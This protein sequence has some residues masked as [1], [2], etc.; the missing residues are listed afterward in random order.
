MRSMMRT[1]L[2]AIKFL[3]F[4]ALWLVMVWM[5]AGCKVIGLPNVPATAVIAQPTQPPATPLAPATAAPKPTTAPT[6][7]PKVVA[8]IVKA[9]PTPRATATVPP[10]NKM[11]F[12]ERNALYF[13]LLSARQAEKRNT[14]AAEEDYDQ[15][16]ELMFAGNFSAADKKLNEAI[17]ALL[18]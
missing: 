9:S 2:G 13:D 6:S 10:L 8:T 18:P 16:I 4:T 14:A 15:A 3:A 7:A 1:T 17:T 5:L 11:S 12:T